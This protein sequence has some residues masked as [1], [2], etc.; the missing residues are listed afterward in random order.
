[1]TTKTFSLAEVRES[2]AER[3]DQVTQDGELHELHVVMWDHHF[4]TVK[5]MWNNPLIED[6]ELQFEPVGKDYDWED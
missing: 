5:L 3:I 6:T 1:M 2:I 4:G